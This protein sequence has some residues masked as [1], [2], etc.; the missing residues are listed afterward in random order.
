M[1]IMLAKKMQRTKLGKSQPVFST[2][3]TFWGFPQSQKIDDAILEAAPTLTLLNGQMNM[4]HASYIQSAGSTGAGAGF[5]IN[6]VSDG[7]SVY[8]YRLFQKN[9]ESL[10]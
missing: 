2:S 9:S 10:H 4:G 7:F 1:V 3:R 6:T 8:H 5:Q